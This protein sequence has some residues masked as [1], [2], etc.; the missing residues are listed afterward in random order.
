MRPPRGTPHGM[1]GWKLGVAAGEGLRNW[2]HGRWLTALATLFIAAAMSATAITD[3][4]AIDRLVRDEAAW[5]DAGGRVLVATNADAGGIDR[6]ACEGVARLDG[7]SASVSLTRLEARAGVANAPEANLPLVAAGEGIGRLL[8][9]EPAAGAILPR[10]LASGIGVGPGD[11]ITL[12]PGTAASDAL[13]V[14]MLPTAPVP[15]AAVTDTGVLAEDFAYAVLLPTSASGR[16][17]SCYVRAAPGYLADVR[18]ALPALLASD[19]QPP[20]VAD[21]LVGGA[22][23]R[24]FAAEY[25]DR[26]LKQAPWAV[27]AS[28]ALLWLLLVWI[29]RSRDGLY[30]TLGADSSTRTVIRT[31]EGTAL[32]VVA[33]ALAA[34]VTAGV[35]R[36]TVASVAAVSHDVVRHL[37]IA[38]SVAVLGVLV[39]ALVPLR[40]P[41]GAL[42][43]R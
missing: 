20:V 39:S 4:I 14:D 16:A 28:A 13:A 2:R 3:A 43:D 30:A 22:Y 12:V 32:V 11:T 8:G 35:L 33:T 29:R 31:S 18:A 25:A 36:M 15:V 10:D 42:K 34:L 19:G 21:R 17:G 37:T 38:G 40:S 1:A 7:V 6:A 23:A 9:L 27:G 41:L 24:D 26:G 5:E